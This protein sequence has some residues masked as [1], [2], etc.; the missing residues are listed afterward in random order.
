M[1]APGLTKQSQGATLQ[2]SLSSLVDDELK[3]AA[4]DKPNN[5][6]RCQLLGVLAHSRKMSQV[7]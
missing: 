2:K 1:M 7:H 4:I 6:T 3:P 5:K